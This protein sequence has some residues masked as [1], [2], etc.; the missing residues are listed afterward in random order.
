MNEDL[1][2]NHFIRAAQLNLGQFHEM[3]RVRAAIAANDQELLAAKEKIAESSYVTCLAIVELENIIAGLQD[4]ANQFRQHA[5]IPKDLIANFQQRIY[6]AQKR[7]GHLRSV[8]AMNE[9][10]MFSVVDELIKSRKEAQKLNQHIKQSQR[11]A[12][13]IN[14]IIEGDR[15]QMSADASNVLA[16]LRDQLNNVYERAEQSENKEGE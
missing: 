2:L 6:E 3:E 8:L 1:N 16:D 7:I 13:M 12:Q 4:Q 11:L 9:E 10:T 15:W 14:E 5:Y